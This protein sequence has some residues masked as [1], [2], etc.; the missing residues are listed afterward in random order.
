MQVV[1]L[2]GIPGARESEGGQMGRSWGLPG[3]AATAC[4]MLRDALHSR[5]E[6]AAP[7]GGIV[8]PSRRAMD[9]EPTG[10]PDP[11]LL[12]RCELPTRAG[13]AAVHTP[14]VWEPGSGTV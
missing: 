12:F 1:F 8:Q 7:A 11:R 3:R 2:G 5:M 14:G 9:A 13:S 6:D 4:E 10:V